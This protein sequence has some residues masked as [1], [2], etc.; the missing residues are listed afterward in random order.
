MRKVK[1]GESLAEKYP[2]V[3]AQWHPTKNGELTPLDFFKTSNSKAWYK[4]ALGDD[5]EW[6]AKICNRSL[7]RRGCPVCAGQKVVRSNCLA[8][9]H[10]ELSKE[11]HPIKNGNLT[12]YHIISG[13][14]KHVWWKCSKGDD[15]EWYTTPSLRTNGSGCAVCCGRIV[16]PSNCLATTHPALTKEWHPIKNG[17][18][19]P[20]D[21]IAGSSRRAWWKC[22]QGDDHEWEATIIN[23]SRLKR[24]CPICAGKKVVLSNCL[25]TVNPELAKEWHPTKNQGVTPYDVTTGVNKKVWWKCNK[26]DDHEWE[27]VIGSR[28][29][30][31]G[32]PVCSG[33]KVALSNCLATVQPEFAKEWHPTKNQGVT[34]YDVTTGVNKK[35]WWKCNKGD[36]HEWEAVIGSRNSGVGCPVCAGQK[37]VLSNC[38][39][40]VNAELAKEWHIT[41]NGDLTP[42]D[43]TTGVNKKV[44]WKCNK[45]DDHEWAAPPSA[46][47]RGRG[48]PVCTGQRTVLSNC[49][50]TTHPEISKRWHPTKNGE[51]TPLNVMSGS[52]KKVWWK[53]EKGEDHEYQAA[54]RS[55]LY[56]KCS[57][58]SGRT[59]VLSNCLATLNPELS[60]EWHP[61]K[62][63]N[64]TPYDVT[65]GTHKRVWWNCPK[66]NDHEWKTS[67][68]NRK[69]TQCPVC[70]G[71]KV[72][73]SNC[74]ATLNPELSKEWHP[75]KNGNLTPYDVTISTGK[76]YWWQCLKDEDHEWKSK[77]SNRTV[78][79]K[80]PYCNLTPQSKQELTITFELL[81][82]FPDINPRGFKTRVEG[83][84]W[85][86]DIY[87]PLLHLGVEF[88]GSYW[89]KDKVALDKL[90]TKKLKS[91]GL[92]ILRV[93]EEPLKKISDSDIISTQPFNAKEITNNILTHIMNSFELEDVLVKKIKAY[94]SK[95]KLQNEKGLDEYIGMILTEKAE[96]D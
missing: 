72:V 27:A 71:Q 41:K 18:L 17:D 34:P 1:K 12:P 4:C 90:K 9:T 50:A 59:I 95:K 73:L 80:C 63:G 13:S 24:G 61:T 75:I 79:N 46:R 22:S 62:N 40:T 78:G 56:H 31:I 29:S 35:V 39:A 81:T 43:V 33:K 7:L 58:C 16:V 89:H 87:I 47:T 3:A 53:C 93:R 19:R 44:W 77:V 23:R 57:V 88:D 55:Q 76:E 83:K 25:A 11:W 6:E 51:V 64:L 54:I 60:K 8:T 69:I 85:S 15:H 66:G 20:N 26:G 36:D 65:E 2:A 28:N 5:H 86:I 49:L 45:G 14:E 74:L 67:I 68:A 84:L 10:P 96:K 42:Y 21:V 92:N 91:D 30:G 52:S 94:I 82:L 38:L 37:V 70:V 48:C 32:C